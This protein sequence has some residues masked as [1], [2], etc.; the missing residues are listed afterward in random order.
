MEINITSNIKIQSEI[1]FILVEKF[2]F[3][4]MPNQHAELI[5]SGYA[6]SVQVY[7]MAKTYNSKV[8]IWLD[9]ENQILFWGYLVKI[10]VENIGKTAKVRLTAKSGSYKLDLHAESRSYQNVEKTYADVIMQVTEHVGGRVICESG[11]GYKI[12]KPLIQYEETVWEFS[13]RL[14]SQLGTCVVPDIETSGEYFWFGMRKGDLITDLSEEEY[15]VNICKRAYGKEKEIIYNVESREFYNIGDRTRFCNRDMIICKVFAFFENGELMF[16]YALKQKESIQTF[17]QK[18]FL[19]LGL[20]GTVIDVR[21][22]QVRIALEIDDGDSTGDY[23][24]DWYP[25]TGNALYAVPEKGTRIL[26]YFGS[27]DEREGF[28]IHSFLDSVDAKRSYKHRYFN[29]KES[30]YMHM[31]EEDISF[32]NKKGHSVT[33]EDEMVSVRSIEKMNISAHG[34][35]K[36]NAKH[37]TIYTPDELNI[38]Q[39]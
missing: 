26:L 39:G 31:T 10:E 38:C 14:A 6:D 20:K 18:K 2:Q 37:I 12:G 29:T 36:I 4:W 33:L 3:V 25:G 21:Q 27:L 5:L 16:K 19:G 28:A 9:K 13:K 22:E 1:P 11:V 30:N 32:S 23:F 8:K 24:Y 7:G 15:E 34:H 17:Y 35:V